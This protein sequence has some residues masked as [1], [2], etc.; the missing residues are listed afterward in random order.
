MRSKMIL[1]KILEKYKAQ[2][3]G[4]GYI[5]IIVK[6]E[7]IENF[8]KEIISEKFN[9]THIGW[10]EYCPTMDTKNKLGMGG[11]SSIFFDGWFSEIGFVEEAW[12]VYC[13]INFIGS[14]N[15]KIKKI[16]NH[17]K[18]FNIG[19]GENFI[20]FEKTDALA[21]SF[22]LDVPEDWCNNLKEIQYNVIDMSY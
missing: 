17:I 4:C 7:Y 2:P 3:V 13:K 5:D 6:R 16:L 15:E 12:N 14:E 11:T 18:N 1:D 19:E 21:P 9:I 10:W 8:V 22:W 20:S